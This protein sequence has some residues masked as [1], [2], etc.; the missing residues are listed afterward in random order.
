MIGS[1]E[2]EVDGV[3]KDGEAVPILRNGDWLLGTT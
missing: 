1:N 3:T 2:L